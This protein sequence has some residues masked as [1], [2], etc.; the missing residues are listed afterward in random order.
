[1]RTPIYDPK[2]TKPVKDL[3]AKKA[4]ITQKQSDLE[5][6]IEQL[7]SIQNG[8]A[9]QLEVARGR[10]VLGEISEAKEL[11]QKHRNAVSELSAAQT[12]LRSMRTALE[13]LDRRIEAE[14]ENQD[15]MIREKAEK[16]RNKQAG[17]L[18]ETLKKLEAQNSELRELEK[19]AR[20]SPTLSYDPRKTLIGFGHGFNPHKIHEWYRRLEKYLA[21]G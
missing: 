12:D 5:R 18:F 7:E 17:E 6:K 14:I 13:E 16:K 4:E 15:S 8:I 1:M 11:E 3:I 21:G 9:E 20:I 10:V 2:E 19:N